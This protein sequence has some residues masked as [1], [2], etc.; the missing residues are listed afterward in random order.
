M[1]LCSLASRTRYT[2]VKEA[3]N[4]YSEPKEVIWSSLQSHIHP[5]VHNGKIR[6]INKKFQLVRKIGYLLSSALSIV[7][8]LLSDNFCPK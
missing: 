2:S 6:I 3:D 5:T 1:L 7:Y 8:L 4:H